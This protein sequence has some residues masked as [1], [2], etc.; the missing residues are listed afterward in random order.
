MLALPGIVYATVRRWLRGELPEDRDFG[1]ALAR[2]IFFAIT[3]SAIYFCVFGTWLFEGLTFGSDGEN[4]GIADPRAVGLV[5][6]AF[7][8]GIPIVL[9]SLAQLQ[10]IQWVALPKPWGWIKRPA[11]RHGYT[12]TPTAWDYAVRLRQHTWIKVLRADGTWI[13]GWFT[14]GSFAATYPEPH[15]LYIDQQYVMTADGD[16]DGPLHNT[17]LWIAIGEGDLVF[18]TCPDEKQEAESG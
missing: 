5:V 13:G 1:L 8:I 11:S 2:G 12:S 6:L 18:W 16:F 10:Y 4:I 14:G 3:L 17:G 7:Y 9:S 15:T